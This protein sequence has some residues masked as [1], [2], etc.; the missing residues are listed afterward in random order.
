MTPQCTYADVAKL[1]REWYMALKR[2]IFTPELVK[3]LDALTD[4]TFA[5]TLYELIT[6]R[7]IVADTKDTKQNGLK[8]KP[9]FGAFFH[10]TTLPVSEY[11]RSKKLARTCLSRPSMSARTRQRMTLTS[12]PSEIEGRMQA[13]VICAAFEVTEEYLREIGAKL[14]YQNRSSNSRRIPIHFD[15]QTIERLVPAELRKKVGTIEYYEWYM[16]RKYRTGYTL[17]LEELKAKLPSVQ[18]KTNHN[19]ALTEL[20]NFF[21]AVE[22][23]RHQTVHCNGTYEEKKLRKL[24]V[25]DQA[26][27]RSMTRRSKL[28]KANM[29]LPS[30]NAAEAIACHMAALG[31][32]LHQ[33]IG[34]DL[35]MELTWPF[36]WH[37][38][39]T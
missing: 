28:F 39:K 23:I 30:R 22:F 1:K 11:F 10:G 4:L 7:A 26:S 35:G 25:E 2:N 34:Y 18:S 16:R 13:Q 32:F 21:R 24:R 9:K 27:I 36:K 5:G 20:T 14:L 38:P 33:C 37:Q 12:W 29:I 19:R 6:K 8:L 31:L 15:R 17:F 3:L